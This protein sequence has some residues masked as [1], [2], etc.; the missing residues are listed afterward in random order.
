MKHLIGD[1]WGASGVDFYYVL[2]SESCMLDIWMEFCKSVN[3][4]DV[5]QSQKK[6]VFIIFSFHR[7]Q[8]YEQNIEQNIKYE[9]EIQTPLKNS[10]L[11]R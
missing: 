11:S 4:V 5:H 9:I 1:S 8:S 2:Y 6:E 10:V 3:S 7:Y